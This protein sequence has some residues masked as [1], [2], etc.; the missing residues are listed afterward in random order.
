[1]V[2]E[3]KN[4]IERS[5]NKIDNTYNRLSWKNW[6]LGLQKMQKSCRSNDQWRKK[7]TRPIIYWFEKNWNL[8]MK[9][10]LVKYEEDWWRVVVLLFACQTLKPMHQK[11]ANNVFKIYKEWAKKVAKQL[12]NNIQKHL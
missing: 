5:K 12:T 2:G 7:S 11:V 9:F 3:E 1:M 8:E 4:G 6:E 10:M